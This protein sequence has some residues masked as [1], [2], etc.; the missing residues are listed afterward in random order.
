MCYYN[1]MLSCDLAHEVVAGEG[2]LVHHLEGDP[3]GGRVAVHIKGEGAGGLEELR[4]ELAAHGLGPLLLV[5][6]LHLAR[7]GW[8]LLWRCG[9]CGSCGGLTTT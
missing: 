6:H 4:V 2:V 5:P 3:G 9:S 7:E 8:M 1:L